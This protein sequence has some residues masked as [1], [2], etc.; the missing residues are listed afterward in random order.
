MIDMSK[1]AK[2][3]EILKYCVHQFF[4]VS[5]LN[6]SV[7]IFNTIHNFIDCK[8]RNFDFI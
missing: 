2:N 4:F 3:L 7:K 1:Y 6:I 5:E 8:P